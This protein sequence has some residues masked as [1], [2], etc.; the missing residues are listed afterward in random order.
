MRRARARLD[1]DVKE[2]T[3]RVVELEG[4]VGRQGEAR[5]ELEGRVSAQSEK[6]EYVRNIAVEMIKKYMKLKEVAPDVWEQ[7]EKLTGPPEK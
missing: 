7:V 6:I 3:R 2:H 5:T 1:G 4:E